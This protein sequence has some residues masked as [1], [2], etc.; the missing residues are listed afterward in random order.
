MWP[1]ITCCNLLDRPGPPSILNITSHR[2]NLSMEWSIP[3]FTEEVAIPI[4]HYIVNV[5]PSDKTGSGNYTTK[6]NFITINDIEVNTNCTF[7]VSAVNCAGIGN[8]SEERHHRI[9]V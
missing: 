6:N 3:M 7:T 8:S 5:Q 2:N 1:F 4:D 9:E